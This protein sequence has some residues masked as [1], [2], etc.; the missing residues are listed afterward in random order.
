MSCSIYG[1]R[2]LL[3]NHGRVAM[4]KVN[5]ISLVL[6]P[7]IGLAGYLLGGWSGALTIEGLW[8]GA[9]LAGTLIHWLP[10]PEGR[11]R[12]IPR[13]PSYERNEWL[14]CFSVRLQELRPSMSSPMAAKLAVRAWPEA[15]NLEPKNAA[16]IYVTE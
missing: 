10:H 11:L 1:S 16:E 13:R 7:G 14:D 6:A 4:V 15:A 8:A 3:I 5:L 12:A 2:H 9:V